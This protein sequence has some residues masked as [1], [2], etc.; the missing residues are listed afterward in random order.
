MG[1][2]YP[3]LLARARTLFNLSRFPE[4]FAVKESNSEAFLA[5]SLVFEGLSI[6]VVPVAGYY[7][8]AYA[9]FIANGLTGVVIESCELEFEGSEN[10]ILRR[11]TAQSK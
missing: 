4:S 2:V 3:A 8:I 1:T 11:T 10:I 7:W 9:A 5:V 6:A